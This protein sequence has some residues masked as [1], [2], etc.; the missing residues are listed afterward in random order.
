MDRQK[1]R[2]RIL[3]VDDNDFAREILVERL[4]PEGY[5]LVPAGGGEE[6]L[7]LAQERP[8]D[9]VL[10]DVMMP[11]M[12]G[13]EV[14]RRL[15][16]HPMLGEVPV[17]MI[18]A[19]E[20]S[21]S[22]VKGIEAGADDFVSKSYDPTEL[23]A[24]VRTIS[25][26][27]RYRLLLA[28]RTKF[29]WV[30]EGADDGYVVLDSSDRILWANDRAAAMLGVEDDASGEDFLGLATSRF[31]C[32]PGDLW[33]RWPQAEA[34][35]LFLLRPETGGEGA[36]WL[37][38]DCLRFPE[39][40]ES[41]R[42]I[43]LRD[44]TRQMEL[45]RG[46]WKFRSLVSHKLEAA[47]TMILG[48]LE[49]L[50]GDVGTYSEDQVRQVAGLALRSGERLKTQVRD[51]VASLDRPDAT[52]GAEALALGDLESLTR[53]L[54]TSVGAKPF[55]WRCDESLPSGRVPLS[56]LAAELV[57]REILENL[58]RFSDP[59]GSSG[60]RVDV[61]TRGTGPADRELD[62]RLVSESGTLPAEDLSRLW[63]P[64]YLRDEADD[65][66]EG[67]GLGLSMAGSLVW[68]VGGSCRVADAGGGGLEVH[69]SLPV[70]PGRVTLRE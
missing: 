47:L 6:A 5:E 4:R 39:E 62:L 11:D 29:Q 10:L 16:A 26:L 22:R 7:R 49:M 53:E 64:Y 44:E 27:N 43:R 18:T 30:V 66:R 45:G 35:P 58:R 13:F 19:L 8:P 50:A 70:H 59:D 38:V 1:P 63:I 28:E 46:M 61:S 69:L 14:C 9:L 21:E 25:R 40:G 12:D 3:V 51:I 48:S 54:A 57:L 33:A 20:D 2:T 68:G 41:Q 37:R 55:D 56:H 65:D 52:L 31:R 34:D 32:E 42:L 36:Y 24:R 17:I 67:R 60:V 23:R 15:R